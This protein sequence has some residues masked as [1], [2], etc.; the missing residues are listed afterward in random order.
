MWLLKVLDSCLSQH[1]F[2]QENVPS[3][4]TAPAQ[5]IL[6]LSVC[7]SVCMSKI[8]EFCTKL[9]CSSQQ[10]HLK[11]LGA[12]KSQ[13]RLLIALESPKTCKFLYTVQK[14]HFLSVLRHMD[15]SL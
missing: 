15:Q 6:L 9:I 4:S 14:L 10:P 2:K 7:Q 13:S 1:G 12:A 3:N 8:F 11:R 5:E